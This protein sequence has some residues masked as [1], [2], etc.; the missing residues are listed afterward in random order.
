[1]FGTD[2]YMKA[3]NLNANQFLTEAT[4]IMVSTVW[5]MECR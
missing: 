1:M 4:N 5:S 3:L 2:R